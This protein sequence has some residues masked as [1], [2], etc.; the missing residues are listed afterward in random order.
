VAEKGSAVPEGQGVDVGARAAD[1]EA[2]AGPTSRLERRLKALERR[3]R[4]TEPHTALKLLT[5]NELRL[6]LGLVERGG[7]LPSGDVRSP[8]VFRSPPPEES[9]A[10]ER[11]RQL[12][13]EPLDHLEAAEEL[14]DRVG[15]ADGWYA[16][17]AVHAALLL[18]RLEL[19]DASSWFVGKRAEAVLNL[20]AELEEHRGE[21]QHTHVRGTVR[22]LKRLKEMSRLTP[23]VEP[24]SESLEDDLPRAASTE[25][26]KAALERPT[27]PQK[28][29]DGPES[30]VEDTPSPWQAPE[31]HTGAG[32][33]RR[34]FG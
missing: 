13:G 19:P 30:T 6:V 1:L 9:E 18:T 28:P 5:T 24:A 22:R 33:W 31:V 20:Y 2:S 23:E 26:A 3:Q 10:L 25:G 14:L 11:W 27:P 4:P 15:E 32:W 21:P 34:W 8:E 17:E 29:S 16:R 7:V 12:C